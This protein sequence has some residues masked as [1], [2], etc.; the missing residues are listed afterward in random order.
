VHPNID[1]GL[2]DHTDRAMWLGEPRQLKLE[3]FRRRSGES[4]DA[5]PGTTPGTTPPQP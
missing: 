5:M 4:R 3:V 1:D 2:I